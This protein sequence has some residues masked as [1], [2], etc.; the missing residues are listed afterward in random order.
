MSAHGNRLINFCCEAFVSR[1]WCEAVTAD[2]FPA[3]N[4]ASEDVCVRSKGLRVEHFIR[5]PVTLWL[6]FSV[7]VAVCYIL[8]CPGLGQ[9]EEARVELSAGSRSMS[10]GELYKLSSG[11]MVGRS[12]CVLVGRCSKQP[13]MSSQVQESLHQLAPQVAHSFCSNQLLKLPLQSLLNN[14]SKSNVLRQLTQLQLKVTRWSGPKPVSIK[15]LE[16]WGVP[17]STCSSQELAQ[18]Q[19]SKLSALQSSSASSHQPPQL[20]GSTHSS[21]ASSTHHCLSSATSSTEKMAAQCGG[22][23]SKAETIPDRFLDELTF[24]LMVLPMLLPSGHCV[25][26]STLDKLAHNDALYGRPPNRS[27]Y[28]YNKN[29][30]LL[31]CRHTH[32]HAT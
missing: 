12:W 14:S 30:R 32:A 23:A 31:M 22:Q 26:Q 6:E 18:V 21:P 27:F 29:G 2:G 13:P 11:P 8:L 24:E 20:Y 9:E 17:S 10:A 3:S 25:D 15:W 19:R 28:R 4:L 5:P 7:P 1:I 16:V